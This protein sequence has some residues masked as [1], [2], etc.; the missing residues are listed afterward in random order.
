MSRSV[1]WLCEA[2]RERER[3]RERKACGRGMSVNQHMDERM[4]L[5]QSAAGRT[6]S[7]NFAF[8]NAASISFGNALRG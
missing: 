3:G 6:V 8:G 4:E 1:Y 5:H 7:T 2:G